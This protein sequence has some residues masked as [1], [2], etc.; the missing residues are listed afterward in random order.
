MLEYGYTGNDELQ[1]RKTFQPTVALDSLFLCFGVKVTTVSEIALPARKRRGFNTLEYDTPIERI[2][3]LLY[4]TLLCAL[5]YLIANRHQLWDE[6]PCTESSPMWLLFQTIAAFSPMA[7]DLGDGLTPDLLGELSLEDIFKF[8]R[9]QADKEGPSACEFSAHELEILGFNS[10]Q[11]IMD[12]L[13]DVSKRS[14]K[15]SVLKAGEDRLE[16]LM[17]DFSTHFV[18]VL[19]EKPLFQTADGLVG[20]GPPGVQAND[21]V[22]LIHGSRLPIVFRNVDGKVL[23][24]GACYIH[25]MSNDDAVRILKEREGDVKKIVIE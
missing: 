6:S 2:G 10:K 16:N 4:D 5:R 3:M 11:E 18:Y 7:E 20:T 21:L 17:L 14:R 1:V 25:N 23:N 24:V 9:A 13:S 8:F 22:Y 15:P 12:C 19:T